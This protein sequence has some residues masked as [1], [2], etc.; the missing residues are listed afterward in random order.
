LGIIL[1]RGI[2]AGEDE[3]EGEIMRYDKALDQVDVFILLVLIQ[4]AC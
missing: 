2:Q 3:G 1:I 4:S